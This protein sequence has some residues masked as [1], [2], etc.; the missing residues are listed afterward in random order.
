MSVGDAVTSGGRLF[1][2]RLQAAGTH[3]HRQWNSRVHRITSCQDDDDDPRRR[4]WESATR[5]MYKSERYGALGSTSLSIDKRFYQIPIAEWTDN[6]CL[7]KCRR[8][9]VIIES[10]YQTTSFSSYRKLFPS[11]P[12]NPGQTEWVSA[13]LWSEFISRSV[14]AWLQVSTSSSY[15]LCHPG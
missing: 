9:D 7:T 1:E 4:R 14:H 12:L 8:E 10:Y 11:W 2:K 13:A 15:D 6:C 5:W 3:D